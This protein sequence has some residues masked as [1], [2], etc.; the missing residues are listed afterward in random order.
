MLVLPL[1]AALFLGQTGDGTVAWKVPIDAPATFRCDGSGWNIGDTELPRSTE[2]LVIAELEA[3][4]IRRLRITD[5]ACPRHEARMIE[6]VSAEASLDALLGQLQN[7][8]PPD[9]LVA[10]VALHA[11]PRVVPELL[12]LAR[13]HED[14]GI[15]RSAT[16]WLGQ[17]AG[18]K[19]ADDLR[20]IVDDDPEDEVREHAVFA[21]SQLPRARSVPMLVDLVRTHSR[22]AVRRRALFWLTQTGDPRALD[23]I[24]EILEVK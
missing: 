8:A 15:R 18:E 3:G 2:M 9:H 6:G 7:S 14:A 4:R 10:A 22:P 16:F 11:H 12:T 5:P 13:R 19:A 17:K 21:I 20:A 24:E 1:L 23:L